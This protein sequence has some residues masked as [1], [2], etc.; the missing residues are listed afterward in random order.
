M[1]FLPTAD[2]TVAI[3]CYQQSGYVERAVKSAV[4]QTLPPRQVIVIDDGSSPG[5][6]QAIEAVCTRH[7]ASYHRVT[8][9]G[10]PSAR[11][12][13]LMLAKGEW[14]LPLDADDWLAPTYIEKTTLQGKRTRADVVLTGIQEEGPARK[15]AYLPGYDRPWQ[16]VTA[17]LILDGHNRY[18]YCSLFRASLLREVGGYNARMNEG[19][20]DADLWVDLLSHGAAFTAV[21]EHLF[22][23]DTSNPNGMLAQI[24]R[25]GGY[26]RMVAEMRRHH[27]RA[28]AD[29]PT[30]DAS[31]GNRTLPWPPGRTVAFP[32]ERP[33]GADTAD[34]QRGS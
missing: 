33:A 16:T 10:L 32:G 31:R 30:R 18:Y 21:N 12:T 8:N 19:L 2:V 22:H 7:N 9:R 34:R 11:N 1:T 25:N 20:E 5:E 24:H 28:P 3:P 26:E 27:G 23:Y 13:A 29:S 4:E 15:G 17:D 6:G 14:F